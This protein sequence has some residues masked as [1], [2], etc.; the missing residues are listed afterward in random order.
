MAIRGDGSTRIGQE[1]T[2]GAWQDSGAFPG[3]T[4]QPDADGLYRFEV[5]ESED[6]ELARLREEREALVALIEGGTRSGRCPGCTMGTRGPGSREASLYMHEQD[7]PLVFAHGR[8]NVAAYANYHRQIMAEGESSRLR[9]E[10]DH[11]E[12]AERLRRRAAELAA[13]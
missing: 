3:D 2:F 8:L 13:E 9:W 6:D 7:C 1:T 5:P 12:E 10:A 11:P 4:Y